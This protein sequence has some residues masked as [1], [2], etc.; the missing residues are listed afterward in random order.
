MIQRLRVY[1]VRIAGITLLLLTFGAAIAQANPFTAVG[2]GVRSAAMTV[3][4]ATKKVA[5]LPVRGVEKIKDA[6]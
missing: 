5:M 4:H 3:A 1:F 6:L 2:S